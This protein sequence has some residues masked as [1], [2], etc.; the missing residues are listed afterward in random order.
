MGNFTKTRVNPFCKKLETSAPLCASI[1]Y[2]DGPERLWR[3]WFVRRHAKCAE[4]CT[5][6][7]YAPFLCN[8]SNANDL[9]EAVL[10]LVRLWAPSRFSPGC[11]VGIIAA[12]ATRLSRLIAPDFLSSTNL[13]RI[14]IVL[15]DRL[16]GAISCFS[17]HWLR[18]IF[19]WTRAKPPE[20]AFF[21]KWNLLEVSYIYSYIVTIDWCQN[22]TKEIF[23]VLIR[24]LILSNFI[25]ML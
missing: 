16:T 7:S 24:L 12:R 11:N 20:S 1:R 3:R 23:V 19:N 14:E 15:F 4:A 2:H 9:N 22:Q 10:T 25:S 21:R 13:R 18:L 5:C 17:C 8:R 6:Y